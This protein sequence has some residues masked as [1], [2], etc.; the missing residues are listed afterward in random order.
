MAQRDVLKSVQPDQR[1]EQVP[2][3]TIVEWGEH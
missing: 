2:L 1:Q 3:Y